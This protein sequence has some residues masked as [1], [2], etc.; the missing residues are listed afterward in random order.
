MFSAFSRM[1]GATPEEADRDLAEYPTF[2]DFFARRLRPG[3]RPFSDDVAFSSPCDGALAAWGAIDDGTLVQ[4]KGRTYRIDELLADPS[5]T[6]RFQGGW[7]ATIYLSPADYH[8]VHAPIAG[9]V[10]GYDYLPGA[11][12]PV[13]PFFTRNVDGL[14]AKNERAIIHLDTAL[15]PVAVVMVGAIGVGNIWLTHASKDS[16]DW[17]ASGEHHTLAMTPPVPVERGD[18]LGAFL[19]GSTVVVVAA[20]GVVDGVAGP[21]RCGQPLADV[22]AGGAR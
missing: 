10:T 8:R 16:R 5:A 12:W 18:E 1:V 2:G 15:G 7:Y 19:L 21:V 9:K 3:L 6:R 20:N 4:A 13:K 11:L 14:L 17:R 22:L